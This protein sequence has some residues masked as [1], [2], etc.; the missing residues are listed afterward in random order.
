MNMKILKYLILTSLFPIFCQGQ[1]DAISQ[2]FQN[3]MEDT[4]FTSVYISPKMFSLIGN[5]KVDDMDPEVQ[6]MMQSLKGLRVLTTSN[7]SEAR[8]AEAL[9]KFNTS[10]YESLMTV[11]NSGENVNFFIKND[12]NTI[13][14][15]L[16]LVGGEEFVMLSLIG[17]IDLDKISK[18]A[19]E[20]DIKGSE[21]LEKVKSK[22]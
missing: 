19:D 16:L 22:N 2:Y 6:E 21:H 18:L 4:S 11:K 10:S 15:L 5:L 20:M 17:N 3:Y 1:A 7:N 12:G 13:S 8:Y 14:E 9:R